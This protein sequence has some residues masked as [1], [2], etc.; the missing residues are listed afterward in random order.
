MKI[1]KTHSDPG[2]RVPQ[3]LQDLGC[4]SRNLGLLKDRIESDV[5]GG[6][7]RHKIQQKHVVYLPYFGQDLGSK[8]KVAGILAHV[9]LQAK[10]TG[11]DF[12]PFHPKGD[13]PYSHFK[14]CGF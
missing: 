6:Y 5:K 4:F 13:P 1:G 11:S 12:G 9:W 14:I 10:R 8:K 7:K 3:D 2:S